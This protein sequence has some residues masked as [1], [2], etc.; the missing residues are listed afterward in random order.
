MERPTAPEEE[1]GIL[2]FSLDIVTMEEAEKSPVGE[3]QNEPNVN[4]TLVAPTAGRGLGDAIA[5]LGV[6]LPTGFDFDLFGKWTYIIAFFGV[7]GT[8]LTFAVMLK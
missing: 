8:I 4:P 6:T 2:C 1:R 3:A 5:S 7:M